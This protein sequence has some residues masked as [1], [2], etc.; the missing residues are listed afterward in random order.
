MQ[1]TIREELS[2]VLTFIAV[3]WVVWFVDLILPYDLTQWVSG[4]A[5]SVG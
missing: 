4:R 2:G 5:A 1:H 3:L